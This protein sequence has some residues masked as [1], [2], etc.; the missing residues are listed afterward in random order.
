M[1]GR[2]NMRMRFAVLALLSSAIVVVSSPA[3]ALAHRHHGPRHNH[4]LTINATPNPIIAG[5]SVLIYGQL[6]GSSPSGQTIRLYHRVNPSHVFT[7]IGTTTTDALGFYEFTRPDG[8]VTT[9][10]S[11]FVRAPALPGNVHSRTVDERVAA[12]VS[13][14]A[15][16][17]PSV[18]GYDTNHP[19]LFTGHVYPDHQ[20]ERVYLQEQTGLN[21]DDWKTVDTGLL[22][23]GS[24]FAIKYR[25]RR[26]GVRDVRVLFRRDARNIAGASDTL[27]VAVQQAQVPDFTINTSVPIID[28]GSSA[29]ISGVLDLTGTTTPD[30][31]VSVTLWGHADGQDYHTIG[32]PVVTGADGSY[33]FT[34]D[35]TAN[36]V[37]N[38]RTTFRPPPTRR[39][40]QLFEGVRDVVSLNASTMTTVVGGT[41]Q[42]TG[43]V[44][45]DKAGH[46]I[47]LQRL[48]ADG[49]WHN[50]A[51]GIVKVNS[52]YSFGWTFGNT[53]SKEFRARITGGPEN[54]GGA[55]PPV[56]ITVTLPPVMSL[57]PAT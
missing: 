28:E 47:Y 27:T 48:G 33:S 26:P 17:P 24:N 1:L 18:S 55:S 53:G 38:V 13:L 51:T 19:I 16:P 15:S 29:T 49:D 2:S 39:A 34:V 52:T 6:N 4:G 14:T 37:Y 11:W 10:R 31:G 7:L 50:V 35:P 20:F 46:V 30:P 5:E 54:V 43:T 32:L 21:G 57:P 44:S 56:T 40:A 41:V 12:L 36:T 23:P 22:G 9:N 45:P 25:F 3:S 8:I 42:F